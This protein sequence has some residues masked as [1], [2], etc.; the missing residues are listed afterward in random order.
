MPDDATVAPD[1]SGSLPSDGGSNGAAHDFRA[2]A[3]RLRQEL[4]KVKDLNR[5]ATPYVNLALALKNAPGG[6]E[7]IEKLQKGEPL[8]A[9]QE[10]TLERAGA[11]SPS[12]SGL[13]TEQLAQL[14]DEKLITF[15]QRMFQSREAEKQME[16]LHQRAAKEFP[17]YEEVRHD[18]KWKNGLKTVLAMIEQEV[19]EVPEDEPDPYWFAISHNWRTL[20]PPEA[21]KVKRATKSE[22]ERQGAIVKASPKSAAAP[23]ETELPEEQAFARRPIRRAGVTGF[24]KSLQDIRRRA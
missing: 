9:K 17:G 23:E 5:Q 21:G 15:E 12:T 24:G 22:S 1:D 11:A 7:I 10:A 18:P 20:M 19:L 16:K 8:T 14:L 3:T 2:E 6:A 4:A 13:T